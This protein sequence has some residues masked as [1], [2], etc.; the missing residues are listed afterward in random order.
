MPEQE[1]AASDNHW[2]HEA[3]RLAHHG[4]TQDEVPVGAVVVY[5]GQIIGRGWNRPI[6]SCDPTAHAEIAALRDAARWLGNYRMPEADLYVTIE[7]CT[8]CYG[9]IVH[10]R[11]RRL[12]YGAPEPKAGVVHSQLQLPGA[13]CYNWTPEIIGGVEADACAELISGFFKRKR[14]RNKEFK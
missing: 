1:R 3:L 9:A 12:V 2:M 13:T 7:P 6:T 11:I 4:A 8:M 10:A 14:Q 5:Q